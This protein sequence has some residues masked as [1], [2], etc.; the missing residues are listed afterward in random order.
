MA[1]RKRKEEEAVWQPP[2]FDEVGYM[3]QEIQNAKIAVMVIA[4]AVVGAILAY[5]L[6]LWIPVVGYLAG[7]AAFAALYFVLP[8]LGLPIHGFKRL[9]WISHASIY[10][11]SWLAFSIILLNPPF[12]DHTSPVVGPFEVGSFNAG[13]NLTVPAANSTVCFAVPPGGTQSLPIS[14]SSNK[15]LYVLFRATDNVQVASISAK[16]NGANT[17]FTDVS[18]QP[19]A[20][21]SNPAHFN[22]ASTY[23]IIVPTGPSSYLVVVTAVDTSGLSATESINVLSA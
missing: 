5:L 16:V 3:R 14:S 6:A 7:L 15:S 10:F 11:F 8:A 12:G 21:T 4:W 17:T 20:C 1:R 2:E 23:Q 22:L 9:D 13:G 19:S 18:G